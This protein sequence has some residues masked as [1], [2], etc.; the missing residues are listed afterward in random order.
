VPLNRKSGL[1]TKRKRAAKPE[2]LWRV[3]AKPMIG[4]AKATP[5]STANGMASSASGLRGIPNRV[6]TKRKTLA[7]VV[8]RNAIQLSSPMSRWWTSIGVA[9]I[10]S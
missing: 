6:S 3:A 7:M 2:S 4:A 8:R 10:A 5:V 9:R 1:M